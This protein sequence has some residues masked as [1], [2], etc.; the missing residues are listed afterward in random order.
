[1]GD[2]QAGGMSIDM[3]R[4]MAPVTQSEWLGNEET[5][6]TLLSTPPRLQAWRTDESL[7]GWDATPAIVSV[8][9]DT[10]G[11]TLVWRRDGERVTCSRHRFRP[12]IFATAL[13]DLGHLGSALVPEGSPGDEHAAVA[14]ARAIQLAVATAI[15]SPRA[16]AAC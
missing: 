9:A 1:M 8:W 4:I 6:N 14:T 5:L 11:Q 7:F 13:A 2:I 3:P 12:W 15:S 16:V 10:E